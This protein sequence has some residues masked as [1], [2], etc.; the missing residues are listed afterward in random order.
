MIPT[1]RE[2]IASALGGARGAQAA[3][4]AP[5]YDPHTHSIAAGGQSVVQPDTRPV[6][7]VVDD[8][9]ELRTLLGE[10]FARHGFEVRPAADAAAARM[11]VAEQV[12]ELAILDVN[13]PG[14]NGL[15]LARWLRE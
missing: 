9:P 10:Y 15:S 2:W 14:E 3:A 11:L 6:V 13:M 5:R 12:P 7:M 1:T 4:P 8:E